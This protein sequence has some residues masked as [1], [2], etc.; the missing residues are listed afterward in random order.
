MANVGEI[1]LGA[2]TQSLPWQPTTFGIHDATTA[3]NVLF[4]GKLSSSWIYFSDSVKILAGD[5]KVKLL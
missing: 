2:N 1:S 4:T 5:L 3:G